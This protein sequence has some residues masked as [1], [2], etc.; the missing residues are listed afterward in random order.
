MAASDCGGGYRLAVTT[1][2]F[3]LDS[4]HLPESLQE[5]IQHGEVFT[6]RWVVETILDMAGYTAGPR[7]TLV[8]AFELKAL[9]GPSFGNNYNNRVEEALGS[10]VDLRRAALADLFPGEKPWR[11]ATSS[12]WRTRK[13]HGLRSKLQEELCRSTRSGTA[14]HTR[15]GS[16]SSASV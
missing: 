3:D 15:T 7:N 4:L 10:A 2:L 12:S 16:R 6:R 11:V 13:N 5:A 1:G 8:A 9:G 14:S